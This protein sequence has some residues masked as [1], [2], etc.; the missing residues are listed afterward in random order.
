M[1][2]IAE[3]LLRLLWETLPWFLG[4]VAAAAL[5]ENRMHLDWLRRLVERAAGSTPTAALAGALLPGC[6]VTTIPLALM[7]KK[8]GARIGTLMVFIVTSALLGPT[9]IIMTLTLLPWEFFRHPW[10]PVCPPSSSPPALSALPRPPCML[11]SGSPSP[12]SPVC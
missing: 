5:I 8:R 9:S 11:S 6:A 10:E 7:L 3:S 4:G 1:Y 2:Q 12:S